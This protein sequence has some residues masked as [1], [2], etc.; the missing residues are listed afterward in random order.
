MAAVKFQRR[1]LRSKV[2]THQYE[3]SFVGLDVLLGFLHPDGDVSEGVVVG[4]VV[5][6][7]NTDRVPIVGLGYR[8]KSF[9][10]DDQNCSENKGHIA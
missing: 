8:S 4:D 10:K 9:L 1:G 5:S 6:Q 3:N 2:T 7:N